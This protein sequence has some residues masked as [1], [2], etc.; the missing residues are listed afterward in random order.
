MKATRLGQSF[1]CSLATVLHDSVVVVVCM[2][3]EQYC[4]HDNHEKI[5]SCVSFQYEYDTLLL[6]LDE[7][8]FCYM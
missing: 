3:H 6:L 5:N 2:P 4:Q 8:L 7:A 1:S